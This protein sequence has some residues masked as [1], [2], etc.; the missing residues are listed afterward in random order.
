[1]HKVILFFSPYINSMTDEEHVSQ[2][3]K[4]IKAYQE[5][6]SA[7]YTRKWPSRNCL[8]FMT[9]YMYITIMDMITLGQVFQRG[10]TWSQCY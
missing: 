7:F 9:C 5:L 2:K 3:T 10:Y 1:M 4:L 8:P 6:Y